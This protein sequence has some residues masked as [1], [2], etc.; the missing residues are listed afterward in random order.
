MAIGA[1][2]GGLNSSAISVGIASQTPVS[3]GSLVMVAVVMFTPGAGLGFLLGWLA[4]TLADRS[5]TLR[6]VVIFGL[7]L[8]AVVGSASAIGLTQF[9]FVACLPTLA[10]AHYLELRTRAGESIPIALA[11]EVR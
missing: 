2:L 7:P 3:V 10:A 9:A 8:L 4:K 5:R 6:R 11:S 1:V